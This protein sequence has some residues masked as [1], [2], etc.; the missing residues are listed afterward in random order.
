MREQKTVSGAWELDCSVLQ[1]RRIAEY[2]KRVSPED[3]AIEFD[4]PE[5]AAR[6][7][8]RVDLNDRRMKNWELLG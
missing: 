4:I 3:A 8:M 6:T 2:A 5:D 1:W 7:A